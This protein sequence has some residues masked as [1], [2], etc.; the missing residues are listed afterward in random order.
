MITAFWSNRLRLLGLCV[1]GANKEIIEAAPY[2]G[3]KRMSLV[4]DCENR[5]FIKALLSAF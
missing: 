3:A 1:G 4:E 5:D 2:S